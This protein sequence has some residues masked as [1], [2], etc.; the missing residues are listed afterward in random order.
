MISREAWT[1][2]AITV[3]ITITITWSI[4]LVCI[5]GSLKELNEAHTIQQPLW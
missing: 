5:K 1:F 3:A 4:V 2:V